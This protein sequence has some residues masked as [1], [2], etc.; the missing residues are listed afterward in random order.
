METNEDYHQ[1]NT[2]FH[3]F[4]PRKSPPSIHWPDTISNAELWQ[5]TNQPT[6]AKMISRGEDGGE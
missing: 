3:Q 1:K 6:A 4:L 5:R 2:D